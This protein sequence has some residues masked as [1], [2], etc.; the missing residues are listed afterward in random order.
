MTRFAAR[1]STL[2]VLQEIEEG[3][4][5]SLITTSS[6]GSKVSGDVAQET[7]PHQATD[8]HIRPS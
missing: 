8:K 1:C 6:Q 7:R 3:P 5:T 4:R 2:R